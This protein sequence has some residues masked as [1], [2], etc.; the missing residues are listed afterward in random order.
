MNS[1]FSSVGGG[2]GVINIYASKNSTV[3]HVHTFGATATAVGNVSSTANVSIIPGDPARMG[4]IGTVFA[5]DIVVMANARVNLDSVR[6]TGVD[7][8]DDNSSVSRGNIAGNLQLSSAAKI[9]NSYIGGDV[10]STSMPRLTNCDLQKS[11]TGGGSLQNTR[12]VGDVTTVDA[13]RL[14]LIDV[15]LATLMVTGKGFC[16]MCK[17]Q[18]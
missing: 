13:L 7:I 17:G 4:A 16:W 12:V 18:F 11:F 15:S 10:I 14:V 3:E 2:A 1:Y 5:K 6:T 9:L 8:R